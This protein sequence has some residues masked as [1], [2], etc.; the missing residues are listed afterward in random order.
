[1][2]K[3]EYI[4][5]I[6]VLLSIIFV[7]AMNTTADIGLYKLGLSY[8]SFGSMTGSAINNKEL[9]SIEVTP[10]PVNIDGTLTYSLD[11]ID[12]YHC[13]IY[14]YNSKDE[15][16]GSFLVD[17]KKTLCDKDKFSFKLPL[18]WTPGDYCSMLFVY[19]NTNDYV[20]TGFKVSSDIGQEREMCDYDGDGKISIVEMRDCNNEYGKGRTSKEELDR[21]LTAWKS[22]EKIA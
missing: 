16:I 13:R 22:G 21:S 1:M 8:F 14:F 10:N 15:R 6:V 9:I 20:K 19:D 17:R 11:N 4:I 7:G 18:S 3:E 2:L 5:P 12:S